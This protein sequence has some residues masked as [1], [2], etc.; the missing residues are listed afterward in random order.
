M[1]GVAPQH[2]TVYVVGLL[3]PLFWMIIPFTLKL[4]HSPIQVAFA[5]ALNVCRWHTAHPEFIRKGIAGITKQ[6]ATD[7]HLPPDTV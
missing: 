6:T 5:P 3:F 4:I 7:F 2:C 1:R